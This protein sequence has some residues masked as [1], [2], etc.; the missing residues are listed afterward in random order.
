MHEFLINGLPGVFTYGR[1]PI[2]EFVRDS[3]FDGETTAE[4]M[5]W[6]VKGRFNLP[7]TENPPHHMS[8]ASP[9]RRR[10]TAVSIAWYPNI[11]F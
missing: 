9:S 4:W 7:T 6:M 8:K 1:R 3:L 11:P 10:M 2:N 5:K